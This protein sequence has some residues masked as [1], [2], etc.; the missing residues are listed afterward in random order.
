MSSAKPRVLLSFLCAQRLTEIPQD[1][2]QRP[3]LWNISITLKSVYQFPC[4]KSGLALVFNLLPGLTAFF[5]KLALP[6]PATH[7]HLPEVYI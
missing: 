7:G 5:F 1:R 4:P 6:L 3:L 2:N